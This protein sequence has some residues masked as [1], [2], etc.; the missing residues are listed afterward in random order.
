M[1]CLSQ[2]MLVSAEDA[3][4]LVA[5]VRAGSLNL[6]VIIILFRVSE[7]FERQAFLIF[8]FPDLGRLLNIEAALELR[9]VR[10][11]QNVACCTR[12]SS[13]SWFFRAFEAHSTKMEHD[14]RRRRRLA[15]AFT[16]LLEI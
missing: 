12:I 16:D 1:A 9:V 8:Y 4:S 15:Q 10:D 2:L 6:V 11:N 14:R 5:V 3:C 13:N 7:V